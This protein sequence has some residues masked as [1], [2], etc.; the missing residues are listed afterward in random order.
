MK[1]SLFTHIQSL[2]HPVLPT[3]PVVSAVITPITDEALVA[4]PR[5]QS[6]GEGQAFCS[7]P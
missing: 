6:Q 3:A 4:Q 1:S 2:S 7:S 5:G